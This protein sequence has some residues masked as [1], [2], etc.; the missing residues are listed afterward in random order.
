MPPYAVQN[1]QGHTF[2]M[3]V[4]PSQAKLNIPTRKMWTHFP[5]GYYLKA[6]PHRTGVSK[7]RDRTLVARETS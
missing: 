5:I 2:T 6:F 1:M 7:L 4:L 3:C